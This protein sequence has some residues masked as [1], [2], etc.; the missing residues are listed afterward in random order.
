MKINKHA[1]YIALNL[2]VCAGFSS[3]FIL[4]AME[5]DPFYTFL[6]IA[7]I[8]FSVVLGLILKKMWVI[9]PAVL[10]I[11]ALIPIMLIMM[12]GSFVWPPLLGFSIILG[13]SGIVALEIAT[14]FHAF[15]A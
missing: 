10:L 12:G 7:L 13:F 4:T 8:A 15:G 5:K 11:I 1:L 6:V 9:L 3:I 2:L 14:I